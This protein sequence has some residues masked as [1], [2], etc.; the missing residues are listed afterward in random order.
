MT[1]GTYRVADWLWGP[2]AEQLASTIM[3]WIKNERLGM[4]VSV[5]ILAA[6]KG[7]RMKSELPKVLHPLGGSPMLYYAMQVARSLDPERTIVVTGYG[8]DAVE[9]AARAYDAAV[10]CVRQEQQ[11]GTAHAVLQA[12]PLLAGM[13]GD[14]LVLYGDTP[15]IQTKTLEVMMAARE[16]HAVVVLGFHAAEPAHYG[17]IVAAGETVERIIEFKDATSEEQ[18]VTLC[19]SGVVCANASTLMR[20]CASVQNDNAAGEFYLTDIVAL[21][22]AEGLSAG[23]VLCDEAETLGINSHAELARAEAIS[24]PEFRP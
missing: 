7:T 1:C 19:N 16:R 17:R 5:I 8:A 24:K 22:R 18:A 15:F 6:G 10:I 3:S 11:K 12:A 2:Q 20:L 21:A 9:N 4:K 14:A 13:S 23:L